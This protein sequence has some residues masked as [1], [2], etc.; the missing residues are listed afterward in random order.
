V[1]NSG[2]NLDFDLFFLKKKSGG[3]S[4]WVVDRARV[5]G[6]RVHHRPHSGWWPELTEAWPSGHSGAW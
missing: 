1:Q 2:I 5:A 6:P 4:P 3:P